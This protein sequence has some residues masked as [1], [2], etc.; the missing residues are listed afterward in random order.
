MILY[1]NNIF[2]NV[3]KIL[4]IIY[5]NKTKMPGKKK[6]VPS[7]TITCTELDQLYTSYLGIFFDGTV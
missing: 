3:I 1:F 5:K 4:P 7:L 6:E 2:L